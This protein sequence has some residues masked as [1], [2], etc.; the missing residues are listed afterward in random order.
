MNDPT[1]PVRAALIDL[2]GEMKKRVLSEPTRDRLTA[3]YRILTIG[4]HAY[5]SILEQ[6]QNE[7]Q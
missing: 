1:W 5:K 4:I 6:E 7:K 2:E 3:L